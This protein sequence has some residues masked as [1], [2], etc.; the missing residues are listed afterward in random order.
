MLTDSLVLWFLVEWNQKEVLEEDQNE[1]GA[2][3]TKEF[4]CHP[5]L[6]RCLTAATSLFGLQLLPGVALPSDSRAVMVLSSIRAPECLV[7]GNIALF[8]Q[9]FSPEVQLSLISG[10]V[11]HPLFGLTILLP[12]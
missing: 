8:L 11:H 1:R 6:G 7:S 12:V 2:G 4:F 3:K 10:K 9:H 5:S